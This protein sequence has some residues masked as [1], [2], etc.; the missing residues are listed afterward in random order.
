MDPYGQPWKRSS[1]LVSWMR[2]FWPRRSQIEPMRVPQVIMRLIDGR[3]HIVHIRTMK[4]GLLGRI[5]T[6]LARIS[7]VRRADLAFSQRPCPGLGLS[8]HG[9]LA[10][11]IGPAG[12]GQR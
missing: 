2:R 12:L 5:T 8:E 10:E 6:R 7:V 9:P 1:T 11:R 4:A 3:Y